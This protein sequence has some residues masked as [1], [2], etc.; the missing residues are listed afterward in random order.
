MFSDQRFRLCG[1]ESR[2][3]I[4]RRPDTVVASLGGAIE[5]TLAGYRIEETLATYRRHQPG[6]WKHDLS[7]LGARNLQRVL[8][9]EHV[10]YNAHAKVLKFTPNSALWKGV[11]RLE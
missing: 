4:S 2:S 5:E 6:T 10:L 8:A 7:L 3:E 9:L 1:P 11:Y